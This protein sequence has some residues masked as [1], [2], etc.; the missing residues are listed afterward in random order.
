M[1]FKK[2]ESGNPNGRPAGVPNKVT[3]SVKAAILE[4]LNADEGA[5][6]FF[7]KL[8]TGSAEDR[9]TFSN[10]CARLLPTEITGPNGESLLPIEEPN[11][12]EITRSIAFVLAK[13]EA[14]KS[15]VLTH[16][17]TGENLA[18]ANLDVSRG[19]NG[20]ALTLDGG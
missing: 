17:D 6:E 3:S 19:L 8:K 10:I 13:T 9:R 16:L 12:L 20:D 11:Y 14:E 18:P 4:A 15:G 7:R 1:A 2:G 5:T